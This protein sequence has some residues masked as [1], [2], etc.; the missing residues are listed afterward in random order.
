MC[1]RY[2][3]ALTNWPKVWRDFLGDDSFFVAERT[4]NVAPTRKVAVV[5]INP[6]SKKKELVQ[7]TWGLIPSWAKDASIA[8]NLINARGETAATKP[9]FRAAFKKRRCLMLTTGFY[10]WKDAGTKTAQPWFI[11]HKE[12]EVFAFAA[13]WEHWKNP[14]QELVEIE[15]C[16]IVTIQANQ[17]MS[18]VHHRMPVILDP[19][20]WNAW[21]DPELQDPERI[22]AF[23]KPCPDEWLQLH[24]V[25]KKVNSAR[26]DSADLILPSEPPEQKELFDVSAPPARPTRGRGG[27]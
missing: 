19:G 3:Y 16:A 2:T 9:A 24:P 21:L 20:D 22:Q 17:A 13:L 6:E 12:M 14:L 25:S 15:T 5:R 27:S 7:L 1:G 11:R 4:W 18:R 10:E 23:I 26:N 8:A